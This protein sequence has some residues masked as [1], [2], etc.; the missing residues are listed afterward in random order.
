M[1]KIEKHLPIPVHIGR[2]KYP[3]NQMEVG[4]SFFS[5][6]RMNVSTYKTLYRP[7]EFVCRAVDGGYRT[8]RIK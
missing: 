2:A 4:D 1:I 3:L 8:W 7:K 6:K 5:E